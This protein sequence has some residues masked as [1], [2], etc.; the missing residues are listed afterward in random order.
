M[1]SVPSVHQLVGLQALR[2]VVG[3]ASPSCW[4]RY[5]P[6]GAP[7]LHRWAVEVVG[8]VPTR[9]GFSEP[10]DSLGMHGAVGGRDR[11]LPDTIHKI[12]RVRT[13]AAGAGL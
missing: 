9:G 13:M 12:E 5:R 6:V 11:I 4:C 2:P 1:R 3:G 8:R 10:I 7:G